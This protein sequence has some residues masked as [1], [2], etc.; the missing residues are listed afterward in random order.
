MS[1]FKK[2]TIAGK[3]SYTKTGL[4]RG[5][6]G[7]E[8]FTRVV[9]IN[10]LP[11]VVLEN[12]EAG[13]DVVEYSEGDIPVVTLNREC[14]F[15]GMGGCKLT[16]LLNGETLYLCEQHY[17]DKNLG[18]IAQKVREISDESKVHQEA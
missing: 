15:C 10:E 1:T 17:Y 2:I 11:P 9:D 13:E 12:F 8:G 16:K 18:Q 3:V 7:A 4:K 14:L 5:E 6:S